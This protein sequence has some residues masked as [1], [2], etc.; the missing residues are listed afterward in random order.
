MMIP[1]PGSRLERELQAASGVAHGVTTEHRCV[2]GRCHYRT[3]PGLVPREKLSICTASLQYHVCSKEK[4]TIARPGEGG[5]EFCPITGIEVQACPEV[6]YPMRSRGRG[7]WSRPYSHSMT[8]EPTKRKRRRVHRS[9]TTKYFAALST[10]LLSDMAI[11]LQKRR[12]TAPDPQEPNVCTVE[13]VRKLATVLTSY[14]NVACPS[15]AKHRECTAIVSAL[16][17]FLATGLTTNGVTLIPRVLWVAKAAPHPQDYGKFKG[18]KC[19]PLSST[20]REIKRL[21]HNA[22]GHPDSTKI[23]H[24]EPILFTV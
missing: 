19:R 14:V 22:D 8:Q 17:S 12:G 5:A 7:S 13:G 16:L 23:M 18:F 2:L 21:L 4:C 11:D 6:Y 1:E 24:V 20:C 9:Q 15:V 10:L 3:M